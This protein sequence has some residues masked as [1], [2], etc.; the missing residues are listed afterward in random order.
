MKCKYCNS[1]AVIKYGAYKGVR[2]YYCKICGRKFKADDNAFNTRT[3]VAYIADALEIYFR[4]Q[5]VRDVRYHL[6]REYNYFPGKSTIF[7]WIMKYIYRAQRYFQAYHPVTGDVW[8]AGENT[9]ELDGRRNVKILDITDRKSRFLLAV[10]AS[11]S[12]IAD[13]AANLVEEAVR[14]AG[15]I[16]RKVI[17]V[18]TDIFNGA[19]QDICGGQ[20]VSIRNDVLTDSG[21]YNKITDYFCFILPDGNKVIRPFRFFN[22]LVNF[23]NGWEVHYNF[24]RVHESLH[25]KTPAEAAGID[26]RIKSWV[27]FISGKR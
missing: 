4:F 16:P 1:Y 13:S 26:Y 2:R 14:R 21:I 23:L 17:T 8:I 6:K 7:K 3:P 5:M 11:R 18:N 10:V 25:G 9:L 19:F 22:T 27:D 24:F 20:P 12:G 15:R